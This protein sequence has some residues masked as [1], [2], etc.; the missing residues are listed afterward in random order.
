VDIKK[1]CG[2]PHIYGYGYRADIYPTDRVHESYC[3]YPT[4]LVDIPSYT[5]ETTNGGRATINV[6]LKNTGEGD[7]NDK[8]CQVV[9]TKRILRT[10]VETMN[11][12]R[13][14]LNTTP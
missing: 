5:L 14:T 3:P 2:Y 4:H 1:I 6:A 9:A 13:G 8:R 10:P 11:V 12:G 7:N